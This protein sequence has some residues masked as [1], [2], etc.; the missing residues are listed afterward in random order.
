MFKNPGVRKLQFS[1]QTK[2]F[3]TFIILLLFVLGCFII[4]VNLIVVKP[5][6]ATTVDE[7]LE[8][9]VK[10]SDQ[11]DFYI[12]SQ[13]QL[14]QRIL[15]SRDIFAILEEGESS[16]SYERFQ[17]H[18]KLKD[19]MFQ[20]IGPSMN[21]KDMVIYDKQGSLFVSYLGDESNLASLQSFTDSSSR[22]REWNGSGFLLVRQGDTLSFIRSINNQNGK[23][24]GYLCI[25]SDQAY[26]Q[27]LTEGVAQGEV[28]ILDQAN[29]LISGTDP[30][31]DHADLKKRLTGEGVYVDKFQNYV[32]YSGSE[33]TGWTTYL[34]TPKKAVLGSVNSVKYISIL[35]ISSLMVLSFVYIYFSARNLLLPIRKLRSQI[36]RINYSN[37]NV[38][39]DNR[40]KITN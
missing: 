19:I 3:S 34:V 27:S 37:L 22:G 8:T 29:G 16:V 17:Q 20:A 4:Y 39:M 31:P 12:N 15:S 28:Y 40:P 13:N 10:M 18:K 9:A 2:V 35:L 38:K 6:K 26:L 33:S 14:S 5:L 1:L 7:K 23:V 21:I 36:W 30:S 11:V 32:A 24:F 25:Q